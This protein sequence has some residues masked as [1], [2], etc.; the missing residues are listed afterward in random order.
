MIN[1]LRYF[2]N[3]IAI[4]KVPLKLSINLFCNAFLNQKNY[5]KLS[6]L[7]PVRLSTNVPKKGMSTRVRRKRNSTSKH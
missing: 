1:L 7:L 2:S 6:G 5:A 3:K 4:E